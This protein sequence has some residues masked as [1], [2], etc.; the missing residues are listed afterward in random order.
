MAQKVNYETTFIK[1]GDTICI[2]VVGIRNKNKKV[3]NNVTVEVKTPK[4]LEFIADS[5]PKGVYVEATGIWTVGTLLPG[6]E[7][8]PGQFCYRVS[9]EVLPEGDT[10]DCYVPFVWNI[11]IDAGCEECNPEDNDYC[12]T[13]KGLT[14]CEVVN[15]VD[16]T[17]ENSTL[18]CS[19]LGTH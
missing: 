6:E 15:C 7:L 12:I 9:E 3:A 13:Y 8:T 14:C 11:K 1:C 10:G 19:L 16:K 4:G 5:L 2:D 18:D 17:L